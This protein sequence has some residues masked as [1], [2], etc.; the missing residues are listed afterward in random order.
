[1]KSM[2]S[3]ETF[4]TMGFPLFLAKNNAFHLYKGGFMGKTGEIYL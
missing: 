3:V 2:E 4:M 1:M